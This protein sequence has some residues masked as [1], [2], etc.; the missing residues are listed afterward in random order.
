M[1]IGL[2]VFLFGMW[3][4][5]AFLFFVRLISSTFS[6]DVAAVMRQSPRRHAIWGFSSL[7]FA[8]LLLSGLN[9]FMLLNFMAQKRA[10]I[11]RM[12]KQAQSFGGWEALRRDCIALTSTND[13][14]LWDRRRPANSNN[15]VVLPPAIAAL[16]PQQ[17]DYPVYGAGV[18]GRPRAVRIKVYGMHSTDGNGTPYVGLE[19][20]TQSPPADYDP[21]AAQTTRDRPYRSFRKVSEGVYEVF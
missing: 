10:L 12:E 7:A 19:V 2:A 3:G 14:L 1:T 5:F 8:L 21:E 9:P 4:V 11:A 17:V 6:Q 13:Y 15:P 16:K 20:L 18:T